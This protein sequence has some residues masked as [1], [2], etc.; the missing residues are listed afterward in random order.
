MLQP[1]M[2]DDDDDD[3]LDSVTIPDIVLWHSSIRLQSAACFIPSMVQH[4]NQRH[5]HTNTNA[6]TRRSIAKCTA[7]D[8]LQDTGYEL[9]Y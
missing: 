8:T 7:H 5:Q 9:S 6:A 2:I 4:V 1:S 3:D